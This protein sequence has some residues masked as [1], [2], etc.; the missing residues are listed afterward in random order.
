MAGA[1]TGSE[2]VLKRVAALPLSPS[3]LTD[4]LL[5]FDTDHDGLGEVIHNAGACFQIAE[6]GPVNRYTLV[7]RE[8]LIGPWPES[9]VLSDFRPFD[10]GDV[11]RD[12]RTDMVGHCIYDSGGG[13]CAP[14]C[15]FESRDSWSYPDSLVWHVQTGNTGFSRPSLYADL[16]GD[17]LCDIVTSWGSDSTAVFENVADNRQSLVGTAPGT[18][19]ASLPVIA[20]FDRNGR[21]DY[22][23]G[24]GNW[25]HVVECTDDN[26]YTRVCSVYTRFMG[27]VHDRFVGRDVDHNGKPEY[28]EVV[29]RNLGGMRY[30]QTLCQFEATAEHQYAFDTVDTASSTAQFCGQSLCADVDGDGREEIVWGCGY[31]VIILKPTGPHQ[32]EKVCDFRHQGVISMCNAADFNGNGY[33]EIF[34]GTNRQ[35]FVLEVECIRVLCPDTARY[36]RAGDTCEIRWQLFQP[37]R[38]DSVSLFLW[39]DTAIYRGERFWR[40]DTIARGLAPTESS[41]V[42]TVPDTQLAW[43][44]VLAIVYGPGWQYDESDTA[45]SI[46]PAG[47]AGPRAVA[48]REWAIAVNP[49]PARGGFSVRYEVPGSLGTRSEL[50]DNSVMSLG[51]YDA[52]GRLVRSLADGDV[53]PGSYRVRLETGTLPT[54]IYFVRLASDVGHAAVRVLKVVLAE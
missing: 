27:A 38:C 41:Y 5:L 23:V 42:W 44:K 50:S 14:V 21:T 46:L 37:P 43:A 54:G 6:Y 15:I 49:N 48:P 45:F 12:G 16:D 33:N 32:Y 39:T 47:M 17:T 8:T 3:G 19:V 52:G 20:D 25:D 53:A 26:R 7:L 28:F 35:S 10:V 24:H 40:M 30:S 13:W 29:Y 18:H 34:V 1:A 22:V 4:R 9:I 2:V 36:L 31:R 11:D 51:I